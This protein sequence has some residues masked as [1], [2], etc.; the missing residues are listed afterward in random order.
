MLQPSFSL[1]IPIEFLDPDS[2]V[3]W[4]LIVLRCD[5]FLNKTIYN[6]RL[7]IFTISI[8]YKNSIFHFKKDPSTLR[9]NWD[10][11]PET[12][13][14]M[15]KQFDNSIVPHF[16]QLLHFLVA[17]KKLTVFVEESV[18]QVRMKPPESSAVRAWLC[19]NVEEVVSWSPA[20]MVQTIFEWLCT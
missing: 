5:L 19:E 1:T 16:K 3:Q 4:K 18:V 10:E 11:P 2:S 8:H 12:V 6:Y 15:K 13:L 17:E 14:V 7:K 9:L 20:E